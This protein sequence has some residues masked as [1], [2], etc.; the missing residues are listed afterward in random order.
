M[1]AGQGH[2]TCILVDLIYSSGASVQKTRKTWSIDSN[3]T[4]GSIEHVNQECK[5]PTQCRSVRD[6]ADTGRDGN[7]GPW[8]WDGPTGSLSARIFMIVLSVTYMG[9]RAGTVRISLHGPVLDE[10][11]EP[12]L[13]RYP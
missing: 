13:F 1:A 3:Q 6:P 5:Y 9:L 4:C 12:C 11:S 8:A 2:Q 7:H 10:P